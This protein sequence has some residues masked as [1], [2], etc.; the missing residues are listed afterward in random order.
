MRVAH[1]NLLTA[2]PTHRQELHLTL[3]SM[4]PSYPKVLGGIAS[5]GPTRG[6][7]SESVWQPHVQQYQRHS[8]K[9]QGRRVHSPSTQRRLQS[10]RCESTTNQM[11]R[12]TPKITLRGVMLL[13][14]KMDSNLLQLKD[15]RELLGNKVFFGC[16]SYHVHFPFEVLH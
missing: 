3:W 11:R 2:H 13:N 10:Q 15:I 4:A 14:Q 8:S 1:S 9:M 12:G 5:L 6:S 16:V 7:F